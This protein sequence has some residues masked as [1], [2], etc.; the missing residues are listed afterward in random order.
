MFCAFTSRLQTADVSSEGQK[1]KA[2]GW[3]LVT[4][5]TPALRDHC[6]CVPPLL[7]GD[8]TVIKFLDKIQVL[9][10]QKQFAVDDEPDH[11]FHSVT[12]GLQL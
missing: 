1:P 10:L 2:L 9:L 12:V 6:R 4:K 11:V 3:V 8:S 5:P 7:R